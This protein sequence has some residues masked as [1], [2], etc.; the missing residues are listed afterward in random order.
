MGMLLLF[1]EFLGF[2]ISALLQLAPRSSFIDH[3]I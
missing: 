1:P 2:A 3:G